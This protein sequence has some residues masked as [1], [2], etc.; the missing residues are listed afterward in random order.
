MQ[1]NSTW[2]YILDQ[3]ITE[4]ILTHNLSDFLTGT[5]FK[6]TY[7]LLT[8]LDS[9]SSLFILYLSSSHTKLFSGTQIS[10]R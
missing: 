9:S 6:T 4:V 7:N 2:H 10:H 3:D 8:F 5:K 1:S